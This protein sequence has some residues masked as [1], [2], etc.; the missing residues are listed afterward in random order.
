MQTST[1]EMARDV[2]RGADLDELRIALVQ[3]R[4]RADDA[5]AA[6]LTVAEALDV[7]GI[8]EHAPAWEIRDLILARL[9]RVSP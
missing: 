3:H 1:P 4:A 9:A 7:S 6:L 8:R 5:I 2:L